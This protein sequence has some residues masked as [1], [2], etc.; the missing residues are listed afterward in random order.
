MS[1]Q[2]IE[3]DKISSQELFKPDGLKPVIA[4]I[5]KK[6]K[7]LEQDLPD[8]ETKEGKEQRISLAVK[9]RDSKTY[10]EK[11]RLKMTEGLREQVKRINA[12]GKTAV[13]EL[14][15]LQDNIRQPVT[16]M[17]ER[18]KERKEAIEKRIESM[19]ACAVF[20]VTP[21]S[22]DASIRIAELEH[23]FKFDFQELQDRAQYTYDRAKEKL[24]ATFEE[25]KAAED[26]AAELER[27][28]KEAVERERKDAEERIRR[29]ATEKARIEAEEKAKKEA[30]ERQRQA[31]NERK[32]R[33][34]ELEKAR[35]E[36]QQAKEAA[37]RAEREKAEAI[38]A[39]R[40]RQEDEKLKA[41]EE[42]KKREAD[43]AHF[44]KINNEA[45]EDIRDCG[46]DG[47]PEYRADV[48][49]AVVEAIARGEIRNVK[50]NY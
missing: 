8:V 16:E 13:E 45:L 26:Q 18:E 20:E 17:E 28:R 23:L 42:R 35:L 41:E 31:E 14:Q 30:E 33:E 3:L 10:I 29:E 21:S 46:I 1:N 11:A 38:E 2:L 4:E 37:E 7:E 34:A 12:E 48:A 44:A 27:L 40:K 39:E 22:R 25:R 43:K 6:T 32:A 19:S 15:S 47:S 5:Q 9:V 36:S 24:A 49:K 50:I